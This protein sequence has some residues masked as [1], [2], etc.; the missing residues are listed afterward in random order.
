MHVAR[1]PRRQP[2]NGGRGPPNH[3]AARP[4]DVTY[5]KGVSI[6]RRPD[7]TVHRR[8]WNSVNQFSMTPI[9]CAP[10]VSADLMNTM[11]LPSAVRLNPM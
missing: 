10:S 1:R 11:L 3:Q 7:G 2:K 8:F 5:A 9:A 6:H 4:S